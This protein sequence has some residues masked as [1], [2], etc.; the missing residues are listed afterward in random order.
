MI[1]IYNIGIRLYYLLIRIAAWKNKKA[2]S[3]IKGRENI[4]GLIENRVDKQSRPIW[5]HFASLGEFEQGR[6]V[7]ES[8]KKKYSGISVIITFFSP[9]GYDIQ[10]DYRLADHIFYLPLDTKKN[11]QRFIEI[12]NPSLAVFTKYEYWYHYFN[13]LNKDGVPLFI[14]SA[15]FREQQPFFKWYGSLHRKML[16]MVTHFFVQ[17]QHSRVLLNNLKISAVSVTGD[18]RFDRVLKNSKSVLSLDKIKDFC[19]G[20]KVFVGGSTW[21]PDEELIASLIHKFPD[22]KFIIAPHS[23][24]ERR[25][26]QVKKLFPNSLKYSEV[27]RDPEAYQTLIIDNIGMLSSLYQYGDIAFI[28]GGFGL[29]IHNI[30]E[31]A[32]FGLPIIFGPRYEKFQEARDLI[33]TQGAFSIRTKEEMEEIMKQLDQEP[34]RIKAGRVAAAYISDHAGASEKIIDYLAENGY[35]NQSVT[36]SSNPSIHRG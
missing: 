21:L 15:I 5:F 12:V 22:W 3:W 26:H 33:N 19:A 31:P 1:L 16:R 25:I 10:K 9:S 6:P 36:S 30:Q 34:V 8:L 4:F 35:L 28:G 14:I 2:S 20:T 7:L 23:I 27:T 32:V 18:T 24:N 13:E 11:A 29:G 17:N